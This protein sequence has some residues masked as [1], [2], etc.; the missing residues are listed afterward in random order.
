MSEFSR[1][2]CFLRYIKKVAA[3]N[4][5]ST[6]HQAFTQ[7]NNKQ[8]HPTSPPKTT[9]TMQFTAIV[10]AAFAAIA[11]ASPAEVRSTREPGQVD[12]SLPPGCTKVD[13]ASKQR[14][15]HAFQASRSC[16]YIFDTECAVHLIGTGASCGAA[17]IM[18]EH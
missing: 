3:S 16:A 9:D 13:L 7:H 8:V 12:I 2:K 6:H 17:V 18:G 11:Y 1:D 14:P 15:P 4:I 10:V 5:H